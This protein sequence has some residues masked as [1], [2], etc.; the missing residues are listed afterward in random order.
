MFN[1]SR[2]T[3]AC[4]PTSC[5]NLKNERTNCAPATRRDATAVLAARCG[6]FSLSLAAPSYGMELAEQQFGRGGRLL[7]TPATVPLSPRARGVERRRVFASVTGRCGCRVKALVEVE[8]SQSLPVPT[9]RERERERERERRRTKR[10]NF[11][12]GPDKIR[13]SS[14]K[15]FSFAKLSPA[16]SVL[17]QVLKTI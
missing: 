9:R 16:N 6:P 5:L 11:L 7:A 15:S 10:A 4:R 3:G 14:K 2:D 1:A 13:V 17:L 12:K 8:I